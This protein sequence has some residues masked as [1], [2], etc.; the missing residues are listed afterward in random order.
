MH[1]TNLLDKQH[2]YYEPVILKLWV[3]YTYYSRLTLSQIFL[4]GVTSL[5][6]LF[7]YK[8]DRV[9]RVLLNKQTNKQT[10]HYI[11]NRLKFLGL[12]LVPRVWNVINMT[13][14]IQ[15]SSKGGYKTETNWTVKTSQFRTES[16][17]EI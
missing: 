7:S 6:I 8:F 1:F 14:R 16:L 10:K 11:E 15:G 5:V 3:T 17:K 9:N 4:Q 12:R 13:E 2:N